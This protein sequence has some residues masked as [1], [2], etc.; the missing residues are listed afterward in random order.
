MVTGARA[1][2]QRD[3]MMMPLPEAVERST[4]QWR[5][6]T[7]MVVGFVDDC[8]VFDSEAMTPSQEM[9]EGFNAWAED[10]GHR[11]WNDKTF[12][13]RFGGH[14]LARKAK[15]GQA[16]KRIGSGNPKRV[17]RKSTRL[18]SSHLVLSY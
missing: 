16:R 6:E 10:R 15:V 2:Y 14:E 9:L 4:R 8:L 11:T 7:D 18:T 13:S 3:R 12:A 17:D 1:W 5:S